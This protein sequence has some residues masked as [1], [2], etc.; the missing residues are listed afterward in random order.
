MS[1]GCIAAQFFFSTASPSFLFYA[2]RS[3]GGGCG[4]SI[5]GFACGTFGFVLMQPIVKSNIKLLFRK[6]DR[7]VTTL[8][9]QCL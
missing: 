9:I 4:F 5:L 3:K 8:C 2:A 7:P 1:T 6:D